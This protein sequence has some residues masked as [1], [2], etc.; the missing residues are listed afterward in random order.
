MSPRLTSVRLLLALAT[1]ALALVLPAA[2][3]ALPLVTVQGHELR[4][5]GANFRSVGYNYAPTTHNLPF[6]KDPSAANRARLVN[7]FQ[8]AKTLRANTLRVYVHLFDI[9]YRDG[10][11]TIRV[12]EDRLANFGEILR[13]ADSMGLYLDVTGNLTWVPSEIPAWYDAM[14]NAERWNVQTTFWEQVA[15][16]GARSDSVLC[17]ELTSEPAIAA[18]ATSPWAGG[19]LG[20]F[21]FVPFIA[22]GIPAEQQAFYARAWAITMKNA[23]R[24]SDQRHLVT[25]GLLPAVDWAF[26]PEN[27]HDILDFLIVHEYPNG[28]GTNGAANAAAVKKSVDLVKR[29]AAYGKPVVLGETTMFTAD[30]ATQFAFMVQAQRYLSGTYC[31]FDGRLPSQRGTTLIEVLQRTGL[32]QCADLAPY[33]LAASQLPQAFPIYRLASGNGNHLS[34]MNPWEAE[35]V[36]TSGWKMRTANGYAFFSQRMGTIPIYRLA[37][38]KT[39]DH[40]Y[41]TSA[42]EVQSATKQQ[43]YRSEGVLGYAYPS[44][45][46]NTV[47]LYRIYNLKTRNHLYT[48]SADERAQLLKD[49]QRWRSEGTLAWVRTGE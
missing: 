20:G 30:A 9:V 6:I 2:A 17:Y 12:H 15:R 47:P 4:A 46:A 45:V 48:T 44:K 33:F 27:M 23:V 32:Q 42:T 28:S 24:R 18:S 29:F 43:G 8:N 11:G 10:A 36:R 16:I 26:G 49:K 13:L 1:A 34:T 31:F 21:N 19:E 37:K 38:P 22:R 7:D 3:S 14:S 39:R 25:I 41:T 35:Q 5:N 40:L